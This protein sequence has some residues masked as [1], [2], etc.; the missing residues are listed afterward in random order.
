MWDLNSAVAAQASRNQN[1]SRES[2]TLLG[3]FTSFAFTSEGSRLLTANDGRVKVWNLIKPNPEL[4]QTISDGVVNLEN[5]AVSRDGKSLV[6]SEQGTSARVWALG[7]TPDARPSVFS[8]RE[9]FN[10]SVALSADGKHLILVD[11]FLNALSICPVTG[12]ALEDSA[13]KTIG[14]NLGEKEWKELHVKLPY[15]R[16]FSDLA[17]PVRRIAASQ[18]LREAIEREVE[19]RKSSRPLIDASRH[20]TKSDPVDPVLSAASKRFTVEFERGRNYV[21]DMK[22]KEVDSYLRLEDSDGKQVAYDD[23]SGGFPDAQINFVCLRSGTY[24][25]IATTFDKK[26]GPFTLTVREQGKLSVEKTLTFEKGSSTENS[27]LRWD[28]YELNGRPCKVYEFS[29]TKGQMCQIDLE[30]DK[31]AAMLFLEDASGRKLFGNESGGG[32]PN[33]RIV[34]NCENTGVYRAVATSAVPRVGGF[35]LKVRVR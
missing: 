31:F 30:T 13:R 18:E 2:K 25:V 22:S 17:I 11:P 24:A 26:T 29:L 5:A 23:D 16:T 1:V 34:F 15:Q 20:L 9:M 32:G 28:D 14:R 19:P 8:Q 6:L 27:E 35:L 21:I 3:H 12:K 33:A 7:T 4:E 10:P